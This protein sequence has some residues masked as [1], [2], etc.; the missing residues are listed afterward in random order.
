MAIGFCIILG[1]RDVFGTYMQDLL[2]KKSKVSEQQTFLSYLGLSRKIGETVLSFIFSMILLKFELLY[3][4]VI[5]LILAIISFNMNYK[6]YK[7]VRS[8]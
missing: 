3:V 2:L 6:L 8:N 7:T 5:L 1:I 4:I